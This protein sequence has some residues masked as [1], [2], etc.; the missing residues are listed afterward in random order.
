MTK[1]LQYVPWFHGDFLRSTAGWTLTERG[2]YFML[3]C[4]QWEQ[5][6]LPEDPARLAAIA[7]I[8]ASAMTSIWQVVGRKFRKT[9]SGLVNRRMG[10]HKKAVLDYRAHLSAAGKKGMASRW[11]KRRPGQSAEVIKLHEK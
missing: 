3:L 6:P 11:G 4:A 9:R 2:V 8:D 5:G 10:E 7:G 1:G